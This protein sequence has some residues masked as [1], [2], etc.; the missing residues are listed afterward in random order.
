[1]A[2]SATETNAIALA[3]IAFHGKYTWLALE[4]DFRTLETGQ[5]VEGLPRFNQ[6][7]VP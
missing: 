4:D 6:F 2:V 3:G 1:V 7:L 5:I